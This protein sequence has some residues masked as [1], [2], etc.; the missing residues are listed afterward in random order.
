[1]ERGADPGGYT[2][3]GLAYRP[4]VG[5][6]GRYC[7]FCEAP[8]KNGHVEHALPKDEYPGLVLS[9]SNFL[10][11]CSN[12]NSTK[13]V[14][15]T[16][17]LG[18]RAATF[19]P[20]VDN[21][22]R[23]FEYPM[24][25]PPRPASTLAPTDQALGNALLV[26][27]G[28]DRSPAHERWSEKD[29]R[30]ELRIEVWDHALDCRAD[31]AANDTPILRKRTAELAAARGF[32]SVWRAVFAADLDMLLRINAAFVGTSPAC[33]DAAAQPVPRPGGRL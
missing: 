19:W 4:L 30:W 9:W 7:S 12:C 16:V 32:W 31:L 29:D 21:T 8:L 26:G 18:G 33:F 28:V 3:Y 17:A 6:I 14:W 24:H 11:A 1:V 23:A 2:E 27:T 13:G 22:A 25:L 10:A 20:D 15:P 5:R